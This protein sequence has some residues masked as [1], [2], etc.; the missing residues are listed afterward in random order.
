MGAPRF[1]AWRRQRGRG[2][3]S[4]EEEAAAAALVDNYQGLEQ[5]LEFC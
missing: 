3:V 2:G 4:E 1:V 5:R